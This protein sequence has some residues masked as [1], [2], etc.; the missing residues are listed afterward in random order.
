MCYSKRQCVSASGGLSFPRPPTGAPPLDPAERLPSPRLPRLCSSKI[1]LKN[2][3]ICCVVT[4]LCNELDNVVI[5]CQR[6]CCTVCCTCA[7]LRLWH[8][9][10]T[11]YRKLIIF[12]CLV[13][14]KART[15]VSCTDVLSS[16]SG[17]WAEPQPKSNLVHFGLKICHEVAT[18]LVIFSCAFARNI[19]QNGHK[20]VCLGE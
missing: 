8:G 15:L 6:V 14:S 9:L 18:I 10:P 7:C 3:L 13:A 16:S 12:L 5:W 19:S 1:S 4:R 11:R 2:S 17:V 20:N